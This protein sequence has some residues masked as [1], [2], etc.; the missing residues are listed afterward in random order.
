LGQSA[1]GSPIRCDRSESERA[2]FAE[3]K[4]QLRTAAKGT[5]EAVYDAIG[6]ILD[7]VSSA[8]CAN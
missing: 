4:H 7:T 1:R 8:D 5:I 6:L 3:L 2:F